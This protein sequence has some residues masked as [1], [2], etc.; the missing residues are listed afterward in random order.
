MKI[1]FFSTQ[2]YDRCYFD[3]AN[4][5]CK[6]EI[7]YYEASLTKDTVHIL[8]DEQAICAFVNDNLCNITIQR[9]A[10]KGVKL[11]TLRC[12]GFNNVDLAACKQYDIRVAHAPAYSPHA[13]AEHAT[14]LLLALNRKIHK[15][16]NRVREGN[17]SLNGLEGFDLCGKTVGVIGT[18]NIGKIFCQIMLGFGCNVIAYDITQD[19]NLKQ[20]GV[21]YTQSLEELYRI[22]DI[23][24][25]HCSLTDATHHMINL[26]TLAL[27]KKGIFII[28]TGR[29]ALIDSKAVIK[30]L[31]S[32]H[33][34]AL[35][36]DVYEQEENLFF[37]DCSTMVIQDDLITRLMTFPNVIITAHQAFFTKEAL[38][39]ISQMTL[40]NI[41]SFESGNPLEH[42]ITQPD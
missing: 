30:A 33:L 11:I 12:A 17:F 9:L 23:I 2:L 13:I 38:T 29:G 15:A 40:Q 19:E 37:R 4:S 27:M 16:Y 18:G 25:L 36:I 22:S 8:Q 35:G 34:G 41:T 10:Q 20:R 6:H 32:G 5:S 42:E 24:S 31:K 26:D 39:A 3:A 1:A 7:N 21:L 28:N 14:A